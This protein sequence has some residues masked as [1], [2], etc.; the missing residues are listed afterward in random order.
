MLNTEHFYIFRLL[1][2]PCYFIHIK[3]IRRLCWSHDFCVGFVLP[4]RCMHMNNVTHFLVHSQRN[5][6]D[7]CI[8]CTSKTE[9][10]FADWEEIHRIYGLKPMMVLRTERDKKCRRLRLM[11]QVIFFLYGFTK[12]IQFLFVKMSQR[13]FVK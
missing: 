11:S 10:T 12:H 8:K 9:W 7:K 5:E 1:F 6:F 4:I 3:P 2:C 13:F